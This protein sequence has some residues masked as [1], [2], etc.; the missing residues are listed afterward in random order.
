[1]VP[2]DGSGSSTAGGPA[3]A[4]AVAWALGPD[5]VLREAG[6]VVRALPPGT[7]ALKAEAAGAALA[8][9]LPWTALGR[10]GGLE[11]LA[12]PCACCGFARAARGLR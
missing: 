10:T 6:R 11:S 2:F 1:M 4:A 9:G 8:L 3:G 12:T 5:A 7:G